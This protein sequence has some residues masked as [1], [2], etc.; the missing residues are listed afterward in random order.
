MKDE[1]VG[2]LVVG[3]EENG[4]V[5]YHEIDSESAA[6]YRNYNGVNYY[7]DLTAY[8]YLREMYRLEMGISTDIKLTRK[9]Y[10]GLLEI[11]KKRLVSD[12]LAEGANQFERGH[13]VNLRDQESQLYSPEEGEGYSCERDW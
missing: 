12:I 4:T 2:T 13:F 7:E 3:I 5:R 10:Q 9:L 8:I 11:S 6:A 1:I